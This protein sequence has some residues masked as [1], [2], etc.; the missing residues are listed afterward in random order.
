MEVLAA[1]RG[2]NYKSAWEVRGI[3]REDVTLE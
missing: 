2:R 3:F 1:Q